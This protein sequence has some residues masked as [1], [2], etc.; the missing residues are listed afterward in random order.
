VSENNTLTSS[1]QSSQ[2][3]L[4]KSKNRIEALEKEVFNL[5]EV[6]RQLNSSR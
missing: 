3:L 6:N 1:L 4:E 5:K 2:L